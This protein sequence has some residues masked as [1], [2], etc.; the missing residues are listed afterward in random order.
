MPTF[1]VKHVVSD[2]QRD[3]RDNRYYNN[4]NWYQQVFFESVGEKKHRC[5]HNI[6]NGGIQLGQRYAGTPTIL[7]KNAGRC[8]YMCPSARDTLRFVLIRALCCANL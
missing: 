3:V 2:G 6:S 8:C 1:D 5:A 4:S 7:R